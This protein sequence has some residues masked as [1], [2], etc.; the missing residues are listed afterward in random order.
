MENLTLLTSK[1]I[2]KEKELSNEDK[3]LLLN[4]HQITVSQVP[5]IRMAALTLI[6]CIKNFKNLLL[7]YKIK[8][9]KVDNNNILMN[10]DLIEKLQK[11]LS[12]ILRLDYTDTIYHINNNLL[13]GK[14]SNKE[15]KNEI[16]KVLYKI[17]NCFNKDFINLLNEIIKIS[18]N[19]KPF[20]LEKTNYFIQ[21]V[22]Y[23]KT[24]LN[25]VINECLSVENILLFYKEV[26]PEI[27]KLYNEI[28]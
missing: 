9:I 22:I 6:D 14:Y 10:I 16:K 24:V 26:L 23:V 5:V 27:E 20:T 18:E 21:E 8:N 25:T 1:E 4:V 3:E 7:L 15:Y 13:L 17:I 11:H 28:K 2:I 12:K 19:N